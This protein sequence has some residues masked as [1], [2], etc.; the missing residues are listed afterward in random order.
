MQP[1]VTSVAAAGQEKQFCNHQTIFALAVVKIQ[2]TIILAIRAV[3]WS[4]IL[5][6][7]ACEGG[8]MQSHSKSDV[9]HSQPTYC[10][11]VQ[12]MLHNML[13][14]LHLCSTDKEPMLL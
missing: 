12:Q 8:S 3:L 5:C 2:S 13:Q 7:V 4:F 11:A 9:S 10:V 14:H 6:V 1:Y